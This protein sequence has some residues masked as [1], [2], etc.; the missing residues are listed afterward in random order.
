MHLGRSPTVVWR[1]LAFLGIL[2]AIY[3]GCQKFLD[4]WKDPDPGIPEVED[5]RKKGW[6]G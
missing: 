6:L 1:L 3:E 4:I 5:A 2:L